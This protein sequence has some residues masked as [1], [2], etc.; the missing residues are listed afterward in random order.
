LL[1]DEDNRLI[2]AFQRGSVGAFETLYEKHKH[3]AFFYA[4]S[5]T[6]SE[7]AAEEAAQEAFLAFL[8]NVKAYKAGGSF[9]SYLFSAVRSRAIDAARKTG[10]RREVVQKESLDLF[11]RAPEG[12][13]PA[14]GEE[15]RR[16]VSAALLELPV[17]QREIIVLKVYNDMKF[18]EI[19][20]LAGISENTAASRYRYA[21]EKLRSKLMEY[22]RNG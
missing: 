15:L 5:L 22:I 13:S 14:E 9:R 12:L 4:L 18:R 16:S 7:H 3:G 10:T 2:K 6:R 20:D 1:V 17:E 8:R 19:A 11:E 21:C